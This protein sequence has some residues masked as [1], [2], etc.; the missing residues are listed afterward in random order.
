MPSVRSHWNGCREKRIEPASICSPAWS[1][2]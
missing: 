2:P 1:Y